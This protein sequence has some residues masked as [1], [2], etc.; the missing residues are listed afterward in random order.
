[1]TI[2]HGHREVLGHDMQ[3]I[4]ILLDQSMFNSTTIKFKQMRKENFL[5][6]ITQTVLKYEHD[7]ATRKKN[8]SN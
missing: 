3:V 5:E 1:M 7:H 8:V 6:A 4:V 2:I